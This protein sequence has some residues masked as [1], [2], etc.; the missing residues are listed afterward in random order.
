MSQVDGDSD[1]VLLLCGSGLRRAQQRYNGLCL[2]FCVGGSCPPALALMLDTSV[3]PRMPLVPF[4]LLP[5]CWSP[6]GVSLSKFVYNTRSF[7]RK[8]LRILQFLPQHN[9]HWF[10]QPEV[11]GTHLPRSGTLGWVVW[12]GAGIPHS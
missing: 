8:G 10:L 1:M 7:K 6:E 5:W 9:P 12:C 3:P 4:K 2:Q 11:M